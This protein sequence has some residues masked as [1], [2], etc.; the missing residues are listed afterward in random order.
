MKLREIWR[1]AHV[2]DAYADQ[3][4]KAHWG[5]VVYERA[6]VMPTGESFPIETGYNIKGEDTAGK[7]YIRP[8]RVASDGVLVGDEFRYYPNMIDYFG[9][10]SWR[11]AT[12]PD[13]QSQE[14]GWW[15]D[16]PYNVQGYVHPDGTPV[17]KVLS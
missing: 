10:G 9:G 5:D 4:G 15:K 2:K 14:R 7:V 3:T 12:N 16:A 11:N 17:R 6:I 8:E 13:D 1:V